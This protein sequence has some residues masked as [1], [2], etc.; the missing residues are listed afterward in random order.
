MN[1]K[2]LRVNE[3]AEALSVGRTTIYKLINQGELQR[4]KIGATTLITASSVDNLL[5]RSAV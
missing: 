1:R 4:V 3:V 5:E 2:A